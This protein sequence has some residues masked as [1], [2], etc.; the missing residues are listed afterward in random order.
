MAHCYISVGLCADILRFGLFCPQWL[1]LTH[2]TFID[3]DPIKSYTSLSQ[4]SVCM[5][6]LESSTHIILIFPWQFHFAILSECHACTANAMLGSVASFSWNSDPLTQPQSCNNSQNGPY[7]TDVMQQ[8]GSLHRLLPRISPTRTA[9]FYL[10]THTQLRKLRANPDTTAISIA[11]QV[12][13]PCPTCSVNKNSLM[14]WV[15]TN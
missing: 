7:L 4:N 11:K 9:H 14:C 1:L 12:L 6:K 5:L 3:P 13:H 10:S 8:R 15:S 2:S